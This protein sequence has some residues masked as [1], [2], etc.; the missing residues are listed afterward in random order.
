[1][2]VWIYILLLGEVEWQAKMALSAADDIEAALEVYGLADS[3]AE[4]SRAQHRFW[5]ATQVLL[6]SSAMISKLL[7][8]TKDGEAAEEK[9][10][11][12]K[13]LRI[14]DDSPLVDR[15]LRNHFE[16][17]DSRIIQLARE[18]PDAGSID[19]HFGNPNDYGPYAHHVL[20]CFD[21]R[22][23]SFWFHGEMFPLEPWVKALK[24][25]L[26]LAQE[27]RPY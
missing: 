19:A 26:A 2:D 16:H 4:K 25:V 5:C 6:S 9:D 13:K 23:R 22:D 20:R 24:D 17:Y 8:V 7:V 12:R 10:L 27:T 1:M 15:T 3:D 14:S 21:P 18:H 11:L